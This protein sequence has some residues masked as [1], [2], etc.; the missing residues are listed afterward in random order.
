[1]SHRLS[2][3]GHGLA[4]SLALAATSSFAQA[5]ASGAG[6]RSGEPRNQF[7]LG[8]WAVR[9]KQTLRA[10]PLFSGGTPPPDDVSLENDLGLRSRSTAFA[11]GYTRLIGQAWHFS[12]EYA[13]SSRKASATTARTLQIGD[14]T[15]AAGTPLQFD[16]NFIYSSYA[17]GLALMQREGTEFGVRVGGATVRGRLGVNDPARS[18]KLDWVASDVLP[19]VG[20]FLHTRPAQNWHVDARVDIAARDGAR[21][22]NLQLAMRWQATPYLG[23]TAGLRMLNGRTSQDNFGLF[24]TGQERLTYRM[25]GPQLSARLAF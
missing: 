20:L 17:G 15:Y 6:V 8:V 2:R 19:M 4:C 18:L 14:V 3:V 11:A 13:R 21:T 16:A 25:S 24:S 5:P 7:D 9:H 10:E 1:M 22:T 23:V 12:A